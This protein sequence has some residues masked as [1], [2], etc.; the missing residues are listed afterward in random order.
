MAFVEFVDHSSEQDFARHI[1]DYLDVDEFLR[2][3]A[4]E[5]VIVNSDS[6]LAMNHNYYLTLQPHTGKVEWVPWDMNMAFGGFRR[7]E[8]D[9]SLYHASAPGMFPLADRV[10]SVPSM[11]ERYRAIVR[12]M[13]QSN[14]SR[15]RMDMQ[16]QDLGALIQDAVALDPTT[17]AAQLQVNLADNPPV[18]PATGAAGAANGGGFGGLG[19]RDHNGPPLRRF[20]DDRIDSVRSQLDG[21]STGVEGRAGFGSGPG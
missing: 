8:V 4:A 21:K 17:S 18:A 11:L 10:L 20:I 13:I 19:F 12:E 14:V 2:F 7:D 3:L 5:V 9:L 16:V 6:P 1:G 15:T